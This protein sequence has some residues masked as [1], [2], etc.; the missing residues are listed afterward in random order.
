MGPPSITFTKDKAATR[1]RGSLRG[2]GLPSAPRIGRLAHP[3]G[4]SFGSQRGLEES[5]RTWL[6]V[7]SSLLRE[8]RQECAG[9]LWPSSL[10]QTHL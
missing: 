2:S 8:S 1:E 9:L 10:P 7:G 4:G 3:A 5:S 6:L